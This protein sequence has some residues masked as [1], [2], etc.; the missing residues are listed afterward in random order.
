MHMVDLAI[1]GAGQRASHIMR[2]IRQLDGDARLAVV[3]DPE[4]NHARHWLKKSEVPIDSTTFVPDVQALLNV[5]DR[6][7]MV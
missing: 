3:A 7:G 2:L 5:S 4:P 1:I 6:L